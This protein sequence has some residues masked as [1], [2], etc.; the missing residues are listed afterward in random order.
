L[1]RAEIG[2]SPSAWS[3]VVEAWGKRRIVSRW[4]PSCNGAPW[5]RASAETCGSWPRRRGQGTSRP[6]QCWW[7]SG[8]C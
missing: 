6:G 3:A 4:Q 1:A 5:S 7:R 8:A 2:V